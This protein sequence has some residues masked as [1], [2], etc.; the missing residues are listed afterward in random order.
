[1]LDFGD[2]LLA[3]KLR[4]SPSSLKELRQAWSSVRSHRLRHGRS[5]PA[6]TDQSNLPTAIGS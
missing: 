4:L 2:G 1:M 3:R 6:L 5:G